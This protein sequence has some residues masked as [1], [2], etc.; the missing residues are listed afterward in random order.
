MAKQVFK[1]EVT[2]LSE[3]MQMNCEARGM[4]FLL[5]EPAELGGS[6]LGMNP[7][8]AL[9]SALGGCKGIVV[10]SFARK[11]RIKLKSVK[12]VCEGVLDPD[13][14]MGLNPEAKIGFTEITTHFYFDADNTDEELADFV[15]FVEHTCPV[16]DTLVNPAAFDFTIDR[17]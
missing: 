2:A 1:A 3:G 15:K 16:L 8:E 10:K 9:L 5:D 4:S 14:F 13:G 17:L 11:H 7:V 6:N 12:V